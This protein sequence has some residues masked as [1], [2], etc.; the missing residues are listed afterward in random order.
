M[1]FLSDKMSTCFLE[2]NF[3]VEDKMK[4]GVH[5]VYTFPME[6]WKKKKG[7]K[8]RFLIGPGLRTR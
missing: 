2:R 5:G 7:A 3:F 1:D 8:A 6:R 4:I